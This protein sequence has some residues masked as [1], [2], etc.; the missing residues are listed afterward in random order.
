MGILKATIAVNLSIVLPKNGV[1]ATLLLLLI[2]KQMKLLAPL[3]T[4][5]IHRK[6]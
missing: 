5:I 4:D 2:Q 6:E 3:Q 1:F